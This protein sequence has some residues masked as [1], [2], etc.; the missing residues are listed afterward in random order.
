MNKEN[1][2]IIDTFNQEKTFTYTP[3]D[4][5]SMIRENEEIAAPFKHV[6][7]KVL[8]MT[9][10]NRDFEMGNLQKYNLEHVLSI[11]PHLLELS[12]E[13]KHPVIQATVS[14]FL[15]RI[16]K[17]DDVT[18]SN[19]ERHALSTRAYSGYT[20]AFQ[21]LFPSLAMEEDS[22]VVFEL[23]NYLVESLFFLY[24]GN[25]A[26]KD[27]YVSIIENSLEQL[28]PDNGNHIAFFTNFTNAFFEH[29][30]QF[31]K[32]HR[33][34]LE[35]YDDVCLKFHAYHVENK[36]Y[37]FAIEICRRANEAKKYH[38]TKSQR[39]I[40]KVQMAKDILELAIKSSTD[41]RFHHSLL[42]E[43][44][45]IFKD[46]N[47]ND[48]S[49]EALYRYEQLTR[50]FKFAPMVQSKKVLEMYEE[51][52][53]ANTDYST[54]LCE[55]YT[56]QE[57]L[58]TFSLGYP[59][60][61]SDVDFKFPSK[62][63][64]EEASRSVSQSSPLAS[65]LPHQRINERGHVIKS[66]TSDTN[67]SAFFSRIYQ[68]QLAN[69]HTVFHKCV[70]HMIERETFTT[71]I[72]VEHFS[73]NSWFASTLLHEQY[74]QDVH[75]PSHVEKLKPIFEHYVTSK[76]SRARNY[77]LVIDSLSL[78]FEGLFRDVLSYHQK[79]TIN[80]MEDKESGTF[81]TTEKD[82]T[83]L[84]RHETIKEVLSEDDHMLLTFVLIDK[85]GFNLRH[86]VSHSL[87]H[88][89]HE[90]YADMLIL[91]LLRLS[92]YMIQTEGAC[93]LPISE[94]PSTN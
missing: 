41:S 49:E 34:L 33:T 83:A 87:L 91:C 38:P 27:E 23:V 16:S 85:G 45:S 24:K 90:F 30:F 89:Y 47:L 81:F 50:E 29:H 69:L 53:H 40:W 17:M 80:V 74:I 84:L 13:S 52:H 8:N 15:W 79:P 43:A 73:T 78:K 28:Q 48:K 11:Y 61:L 70:S 21:H 51:Q 26:H 72:F 44:S 46:K 18:I 4:M 20:N 59:Y 60:Q 5:A 86:N 14:D 62:Q 6:F 64:T 37:D 32:E 57:L 92:K 25:Q 56:P 58:R 35:A 75:V 93:A 66:Y 88:Q 94:Q 10:H 71:D 82:I 55:Q 76:V 36:V 67:S 7:C 65:L 3:N 22:P 68:E 54:Y 39:D 19:T 63:K 12:Q 1:Q 9:P 77:M 2:F 31:L 42:L